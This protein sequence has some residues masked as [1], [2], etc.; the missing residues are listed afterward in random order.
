MGFMKRSGTTTGSTPTSTLAHEPAHHTTYDADALAAKAQKD[1]Y[2]LM[3]WVD[4]DH[5]DRAEKERQE[6]GR[7]EK[8]RGAKEEAKKAEEKKQKA[9]DDA[10]ATAIGMQLALFSQNMNGATGR[11]FIQVLDSIDNPYLREQVKAR[12]ATH[13]GRSLEGFIRN[14]DDWNNNGD[15]RDRDAA[16]ALIDDKRSKAEEKLSKLSPD[17]RA[18]MKREA[19]KRATAILAAKSLHDTSDEN[20]HKILKELA[21]CNE[22]EIEMLRTSLRETS[23]GEENL[24]QALD[25]GMSGKN[26]DAAVAMLAGNRVTNAQLELVKVKDATRM[27][28]RIDKMSPE[29]VATLRDNPATHMAIASLENPADR[30]ELRAALT[31]NKAKANAVKLGNALKPKDEGFIMPSDK[32]SIENYK[33]RSPDEVLKLFEGMAPEDVK[34]AVAE[35]NSANPLRPME[36]MLEARWGDDDDK[37]EFRRIQAMIKGDKSQNQAIRAS[38][39][40]RENNQEMIEAALATGSPEERAK[41]EKALIEEDRYH[42]KIDLITNGTNVLDAEKMA[43][44]RDAQTQLKD[45]YAKQQKEKA[46]DAAKWSELAVDDRVNTAVEESKQRAKEEI[47]DKQNASLELLATGKVSVATDMH[48]TKDDKARL[49]V[50]SRLETDQDLQQA[51]ELYEK[52]HGKPMLPYPGETRLSMNATE[53]KIDNIRR[54]GPVSTRPADLQAKL[55]YQIMLLQHSDALELDEAGRAGGG[56][57]HF[58][59]QQVRRQA[60]M[61][62]NPKYLVANPRTNPWEAIDSSGAHVPTREEIEADLPLRKLSDKDGLKK[63]VTKED[64]DRATNAKAVADDTQSEAKKRLADRRVKRLAMIAKVAGALTGNPLIAA[65]IQL[66]EGA[67][68]MAIKSEIMGRDYDPKEDLQGLAI[69]MLAEVMSGGVAGKFGAYAGSVAKLGVNE[70]IGGI[71]QGKSASDILLA[72]GTGAA[73]AAIPGAL[74]ERIRSAIASGSETLM[75]KVVGEVVGHLG[76]AGMST[77][78]AVAGGASVGDAA[79]DAGISMGGS[80][81]QKAYAPAK[82]EVSAPHA[83]PSNTNHPHPSHGVEKHLPGQ[84]IERHPHPAHVEPHAHPS[85]AHPALPHAHPAAAHPQLVANGHHAETDHLVRAGHADSAAGSRTS[86]DGSTKDPAAYRIAGNSIEQVHAASLERA[87]MTKEQRATHDAVVASLENPAAH[88]MI[89]RALAAGNSIESVVK[90]RDAMRGMR[91]DEILRRFSG[92]GLAQVYN[93]SCV[94]A[95]YQIVIADRDPVYA[96]TLRENHGQELQRGQESAL[97]QTGGRRAQR[98]DAHDG[99]E[100]YKQLT[101]DPKRKKQLANSFDLEGTTGIEP[102]EMVGTPLHARLEKAVQSR[103]E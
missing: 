23:M 47:D 16:L 72:L 95:A 7:Q 57:Q 66:G 5:D 54:Y 46:E 21:G 96:L 39:G 18:K 80:L 30:E 101:V 36:S 2:A 52:R 93:E 82:R 15:G 100:P 94:P 89:E 99:P 25:D 81:K 3:P 22:V 53:L 11:Q 102:T 70:G 43:V 87:K 49:E 12:F 68:G 50:L 63:D 79:L 48:R 28:E 17:D 86:L 56:T 1:V 65:A 74:K 62:E 90:L 13:T 60:S 27:R 26:E 73:G 59:R 61:L 67:I 29:D 78:I 14:S 10:K 91:H 69:K 35:W 4:H 98:R 8:E 24:Y 84:P 32:A 44:G 51:M 19:D 41:I 75:R 58:V 37:T 83:S 45:H 77:A 34:A 38:Q 76:E 42:N 40:M 33:R 88:A 9:I 97:V 6:K 20:E 85:D 71:A 103:Y 31:G 64:Y 55:D 92:D